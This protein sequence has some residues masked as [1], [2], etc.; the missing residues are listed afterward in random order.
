V[1]SLFS[2]ISSN[3]AKNN[4]IC[5]NSQKLGTSGGQQQYCQTLTSL[6]L[7]YSHEELKSYTTF[8]ITGVSAATVPWINKASQTFWNTTEGEISK[9]SLETLR[10]YVLTKYTDICAKRKVLNFAKSF[11]RYLTKTRLDTRYKEFDLFLEMSKEVK[12]SKR[13]TQRIV[14]T[15][16]IKTVLA[17]I[18]EGLEN[19]EF[20]TRQCQNYKALVLFGAYTGQRPIATIRKLTVGQFRAALRR[21]PPVLDVLPQQDKIRM[22]HYVPLHPCVVDTVKPLLDGRNRKDHTSIFAHEYFDKWTRRKKIPLVHDGHFVCGDLR[23]FA[24]Q[25]GDVI[26]WEQSN[27]SY[28]LTHG[29]SGIEW[30]HYRHSLPENVYDI[31]MKYWNDVCFVR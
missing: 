6:E 18:K 4:D 22:Q 20:T 19:R 27:R 10:G 9:A 13:I 25:L 29:V 28:I 7:A 15:E 17:A 12:E 24:E 2:N 8:R 16:D 21:D 11:L 3:K 23:K 31:Y 30:S 26:S 5:S 14:M 1:E